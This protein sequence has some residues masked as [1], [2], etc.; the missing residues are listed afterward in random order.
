MRDNKILFLCTDH[1]GLYKIFEEGIKKYSD[2]EVTTILYKKFKYKSLWQRTKNFL[3]KLILQKNLKHLW[4]GKELFAPIS[5]NDRFDCVFVICPDALHSDHLAY[6][7]TISKKSIVYY[8]DGFDH[9]PDYKRTVEFFD[10]CFSFDPVDVKKYKLNFITN[11]YFV[12]DRNTDAKM[13][14]FFLSSYDRRFPVVEKITSL[15]VKQGKKILVYQ[16]V[17]DLSKVKILNNNS[18][19][20]F[21]DKHISFE[22][23]I[24]FMK[25]T[26]IVLDIHKEIQNG[27]SFRV[28]EAMGLGKKLI[29]TNK[30]IIN[31]DFYNPNNIFVWEKDT[32]VLP[33]DFLNT[34]YQEL[35]ED[36]YKKYS[37]ESWVKKVFDL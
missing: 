29:T 23:T 13:D 1:F 25:D 6:L 8:W 18:N 26:K 10:K 12:E 35:P 24:Q 31:Y 37:Q 36:I 16:H 4:A 3:S 5:E 34:P 9:F 33:E 32:E 21:I 2:Y 15:L 14:M 22:K 17:K 7:N 19:I 11:F 27:L 30:D 28:F 20:K